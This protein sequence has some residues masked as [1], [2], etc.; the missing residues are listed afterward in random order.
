M[1]FAVLM[2]ERDQAV[3]DADGR[4]VE[5]HQRVERTASRYWMV[6]YKVALDESLRDILRIVIIE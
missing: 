6:W 3:A 5:V 4:H 2:W 1:T